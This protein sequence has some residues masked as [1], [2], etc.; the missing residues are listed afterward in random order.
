MST[1]STAVADEHV[2]IVHAGEHA[3]DD[4]AVK[5]TIVEPPS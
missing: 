1:L 5:L 3:S 4:L 2:V